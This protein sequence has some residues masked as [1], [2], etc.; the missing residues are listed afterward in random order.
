MTVAR[1]SD[2]A[3]AVAVAGEGRSKMAMVNSSFFAI[4]ASAERYYRYHNQS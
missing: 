1:P 4:S 2:S 3:A